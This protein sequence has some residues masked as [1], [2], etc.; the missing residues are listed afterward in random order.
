MS[1]S[2]RPLKVSEDL[3]RTYT[4]RRNSHLAAA[5][6]DEDH[7]EEP[8]P[9]AFVEGDEDFTFTDKKDKPGSDRETSKRHKVSIKHEF[10]IIN[11][12]VIPIHFS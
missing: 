3:V 5:M 9:Y 10:L 12:I 6:A 8:D 11:S 7:E 4:Q 1:G 2:G